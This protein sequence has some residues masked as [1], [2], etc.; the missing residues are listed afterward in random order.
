MGADFPTIAQTLAEIRGSAIY[1]F[2]VPCL[3]TDSCRAP[4]VTMA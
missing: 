4:H 3:F 1:R 2:G